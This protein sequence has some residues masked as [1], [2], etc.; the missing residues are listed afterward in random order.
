MRHLRKYKTRKMK[1]GRTPEEI[2]TANA[3]IEEQRKKVQDAKDDANRANEQTKLDALLKEEEEAKKLEE[4][5]KTISPN[6]E[7]KDKIIQANNEYRKAENKDQRITSKQKILSLKRDN[8]ADLESRLVASPPA[9]K[10]RFEQY[11]KEEQ[12][13]IE[14]IEKEITLLEQDESSSIQR[15]KGVYSPEDKERIRKAVRN[16]LQRL[17]DCKS[18][19]S[20]KLEPIVDDNDL[21]EILSKLEPYASKNDYDVKKGFLYGDMIVEKPLKEKLEKRNRE[22]QSLQQQGLSLTDDQN[23]ELEENKKQLENLN[24]SFLNNLPSFTRGNSRNVRSTGNFEKF[25]QPKSQVKPDSNFTPSSIN[26]TTM[27]NLGNM[28]VVARTN[29]E[30][31]PKSKSFFGLFGGKS[32]KNRRQRRNRTRRNK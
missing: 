11:I 10:P 14:K 32:R 4:Y 5:K 1:G 18:T 27:S 9:D 20:E 12:Q 8:L 24:N 31:P 30:P 2:Q 7:I 19:S 3:Q 29:S 17:K 25:G 6:E 23:K 22:L 28:P 15:I 16:I 13:D 21:Y 26:P